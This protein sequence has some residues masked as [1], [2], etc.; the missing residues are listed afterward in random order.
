LKR[1][2]AAGHQ[3]EKEKAVL[4]SDVI[5]LKMDLLARSNQ[6]KSKSIYNTTKNMINEFRLNTQIHE[7]DEK[8]L[9]DFEDWYITSRVLS[10][11]DY[12]VESYY[13]TLSVYLRSL[14]AV[15]NLALDKKILDHTYNSHLVKTNMKS[16]LMMSIRTS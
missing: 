9:R 2:L 13:N 4:F 5:D 1:R 11:N 8:Y 15:I 7:I 10:G 14:K 12:N 16:R 3:F 6:L